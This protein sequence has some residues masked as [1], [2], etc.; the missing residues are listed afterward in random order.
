VGYK[1]VL[2]KWAEGDYSERRS[3]IGW[4]PEFDMYVER[5]YAALK[6]KQTKLLH[7]GLWNAHHR[8][9]NRKRHKP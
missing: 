8:L 3:T 4:P 6:A 7:S 5:S 2:A 9:V 1:A